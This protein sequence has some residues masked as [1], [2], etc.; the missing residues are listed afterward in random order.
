MLV[1]LALTLFYILYRYYEGTEEEF[2]AVNDKVKRGDIVGVR[3]H[4]G[5]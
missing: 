1:I 2:I 3:G 5:R 4:P